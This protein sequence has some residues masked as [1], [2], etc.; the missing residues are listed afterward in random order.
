[1]THEMYT[2]NW[3]QRHFIIIRGGL[4]EERTDII[5][6]FS[7]RKSTISNSETYLAF[8]MLYFFE[9]NIPVRYY[10]LFPR[11]VTIFNVYLLKLFSFAPGRQSFNILK[12]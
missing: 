6:V 2:E 1:M 12:F 4:T 11:H 9:Y 3:K 8:K 10:N 7:K 5:A